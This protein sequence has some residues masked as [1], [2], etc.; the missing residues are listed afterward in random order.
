MKTTNY[1]PTFPSFSLLASC[2]PCWRNLRKSVRKKLKEAGYGSSI[3]PQL[4]V[5]HRS[6]QLTR[7]EV[8]GV[9]NRPPPNPV[10]LNS[11]DPQ[12]RCNGHIYLNIRMGAWC[13]APRRP[14]NPRRKK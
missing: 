1:F 11:V 8:R 3:F 13:S 9:T 7:E 6:P 10:V 12:P 2:P 14:S 5:P 4:G